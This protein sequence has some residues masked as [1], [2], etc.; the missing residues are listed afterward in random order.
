MAGLQ[1]IQDLEDHLKMVFRAH[2]EDI[3]YFLYQNNI[4]SENKYILAT[5]FQSNV[6]LQDRAYSVFVA[7][8]EA[9]LE[10]DSKFELLT[11]YFRG[12]PKYYGSTLSK[13]EVKYKT[14]QSCV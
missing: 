5:D 3:A 8:K 1:T 4:L 2:L 14:L 6:R 11:E 7:L 10:D 13:M 9:V 12:N